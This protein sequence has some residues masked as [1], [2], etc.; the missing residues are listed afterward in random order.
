MNCIGTYDGTI[1]Y[2]PANKFC[3]VSVKTADQSVPAEARSNRRYKD[4]LI[5]FTAVG[6]EIPRTDAVEL[7][8][9]GEWAKGKYGV[10]LQVEQWREIVPRTKNG[11]E[12]YCNGHGLWGGGGMPFHPDYL[13]V[14]GWDHY[15]I[16][17]VG[18]AENME[19]NRCRI[20]RRQILIRPQCDSGDHI[21]IYSVFDIRGLNFSFRRSFIKPDDTNAEGAD[22]VGIVLLPGGV[23]CPGGDAKVTEFQE[24]GQRQVFMGKRGHGF[25]QIAAGHLIIQAGFSSCHT[26]ILAVVCEIGNGF[27]QQLVLAGNH[28][29]IIDSGCLSDHHACIFRTEIPFDGFDVALPLAADD[30]GHRLR[31]LNAGI[32]S[33]GLEGETGAAQV[34]Q[35][36]DFPKMEKS[37]LLRPV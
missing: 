27:D 25:P 17:P 16:D 29:L 30:C 12:G 14:T 23:A 33:A 32:G 3:I 15:I 10:Q 37:G 1:F 35:F 6:Y 8:L 11:V 34:L 36:V 9:D 5:R 19:G 21:R 2:N 24:H 18:G 4:H 26:V 7:E 20:I 22:D 13:T 28:P 31:G